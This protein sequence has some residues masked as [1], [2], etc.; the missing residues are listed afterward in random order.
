MP[1]SKNP[2]KKYSQ[3]IPDIKDW[4]IYKLHRDRAQFVRDIQQYT[5]EKLKEEHKEKLGQIIARTSYLERIRIK[6]EPWKVD[7]PDE[8]QF[9]RR[10]RNRLAGE[11]LDRSPDEAKSINKE[12]LQKI[13]HRYSEEIVGTFR[14]KTFLFARKFL[15]FFFNRLLNTAASRNFRRIYN[16]KYRLH[17][18][19]QAQ[20]DIEKLR[21]LAKEG[22]VVIVPTHF[23]NLDSILIGYIL[24]EIIGF[25]SLFYGAGLNLY[26][27]GY[28]AYFMNRMGAYR[29]D[30][31]K[32]NP[33]YLE[34]L[35]SVSNLAIQRGV[36]SLFFPGGTRS[37]SGGLETR[38]KL[39]LLGT[40]LEAQRTHYQHGRDEKIFVVPLVIG[41]HVVLDAK[42]LIEQ[43]LK[44]TGKEFYIS[45]SKK[46]F[47]LR[48]ILRFTWKVFSRSSDITLSVGKPMD[49][50]GNFVDEKGRSYDRFGNELDVSDYF[51]TGNQITANHQREEEYTRILAERITERYHKDNVVLSSHV[52]AFVAFEWLLGKNPSLDLFGVL[53]LPPEEFT[54]SEPELIQGIQTLQERLERLSAKGHIKLSKQ[55]RLSA[56][57]L[58]KD[59]IKNLGVFHPNKPLKFNKKG[60]I[61]SDEFKLLY[62]YH[63]RLSNYG[64][65]DIYKKVDSGKKKTIR[66]DI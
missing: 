34:T 7:P 55:I 16:R 22:T 64:F 31:R 21:A 14:E 26:N 57:E 13:I 10:I 25:P 8:R 65:E 49:V 33:I 17:D 27:T 60:N 42:E 18:R 58:L 53:R 62:F 6:E 44:R 52:V 38:L 48:K 3:V 23:S 37:R 5:Y 47:S 56:V 2:N 54:F 50:L 4:P 46:G 59:G 61:V 35:K 39:G 15:T 36:H 66:V 30:R 40:V 11:S 51:K 19:L 45:S 43:H 32:K 20:G 28:T 29:V 41:Y 1:R 9:W 12:I 24:D 63:N